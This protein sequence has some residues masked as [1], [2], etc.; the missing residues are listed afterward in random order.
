M[1]RVHSK[2]EYLIRI[3]FSKAL[4]LVQHQHLA[5][6]FTVAAS[7][8]STHIKELYNQQ[9]SI[10]AEILIF[11]KGELVAVHLYM[12]R[13]SFRGGDLPPPLQKFLPPINLNAPEAIYESAKCKN[14]LEQHSQVPECA[15]ETI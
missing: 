1:P 3:H 6:F 2:R 10:P 11:I 9:L 13:V 12:V 14:F 5:P 4:P 15:P 7:L 8:Y